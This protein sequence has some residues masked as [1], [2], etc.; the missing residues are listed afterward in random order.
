MNANILKCM[1]ETNALAIILA[2]TTST[3]VH[4]F[5]LEKKCSWERN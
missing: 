5:Y 2:L 1:N 4:G 3:Y